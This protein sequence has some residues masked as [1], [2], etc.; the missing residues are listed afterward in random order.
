MDAR[1]LLSGPKGLRLRRYP[2]SAELSPWIDFHWLIDWDLPPGQVEQ[3]QVLP[4][5]HPHLVFEAGATALHGVARGV[6]TR[7]M[8]GSGR[9]HGLRFF[10]LRSWLTQPLLAFSDSQT[11]ASPCLDRPVPEAEAWVLQTQEDAEAVRRAEAL[12]LPQRPPLDPWLPRLRALIDTVQQDPGLIRAQQ[13]QAI[14]GL[15]ERALQ[16]LFADYLGVTPKWL[17]QR[18]RAQDAVQRLRAADCPPLAEL[19]LELGFHDQA[20]FTRSLHR[21]VGFTPQQLR[22]RGN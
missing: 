13:L 9:V 12:L 16:R 7:S 3:Q 1:A 18:A 6:Y 2:A 15:S 11:D 8:Q 17:L 10:G 5:P 19:A 21:L 22:R 20:H 14:L 4:F